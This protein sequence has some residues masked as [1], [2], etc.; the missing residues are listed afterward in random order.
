MSGI[1]ELFGVMMAI[2]IPVAMGVVIISMSTKRL[3]LRRP[4]V[5]SRDL[6]QLHARIDALERGQSQVHELAERLD[7]V[8]RMLPA[9]RERKSV[10]EQQGKR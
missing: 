8:E 7:F 2:M 3:K 4:V 1:L 10:P 9:L 5:S 6:E